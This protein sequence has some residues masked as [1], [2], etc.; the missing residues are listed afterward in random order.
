MS[1]RMTSFEYLLIASRAFQWKNTLLSKTKKVIAFSFLS[2]VGVN[3]DLVD[4][5]GTFQHEAFSDPYFGAI[6]KTFD[7]MTGARGFG[8]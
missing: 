8:Y 3:R 4:Q 7:Y 5:P 1:A 2:S 6:R